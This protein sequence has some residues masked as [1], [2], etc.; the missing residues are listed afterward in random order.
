MRRIVLVLA[1]AATIACGR[2]SVVA[3][4]PTPMPTPMPTPPSPTPPAPGTTIFESI[5]I[6]SNTLFAAG[7]TSGSV[8]RPVSFSVTINTD[9]ND[10]VKDVLVDWGD[11][12]TVD[13]GAVSQ[14]AA[15]HSFTTS[16]DFVLTTKVE[17]SSGH[18]GTFP[19]KFTIRP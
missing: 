7:A 1:F 10:S 8:G 5:T 16:G 15:S 12:A 19:I 9:V 3:P 2:S 11:G 18:R 6:G 14:A 13:F 17:T 4:T